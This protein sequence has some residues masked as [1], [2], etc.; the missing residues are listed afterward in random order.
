LYAGEL[1]SSGPG[2]AAMPEEVIFGDRN[3]CRAQELGG[4]T[5]LAAQVWLLS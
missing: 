2:G 5:G 3:R 1:S 4:W